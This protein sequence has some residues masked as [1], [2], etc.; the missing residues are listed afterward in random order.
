[1]S[2][3]SLSIVLDTVSMKWMMYKVGYYSAKKPR[4]IEDS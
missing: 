1:M 2:F 3:L 4:G